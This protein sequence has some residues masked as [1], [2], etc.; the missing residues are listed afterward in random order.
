MSEMKT[1]PNGELERCVLFNKIFFKGRTIHNGQLSPLCNSDVAYF[2]TK[3][4]RR[5]V[6]L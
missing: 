6:Q 1:V 3:Y 2:P 5:F 4:I